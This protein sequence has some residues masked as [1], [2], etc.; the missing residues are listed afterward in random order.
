MKKVTDLVEEATNL[1]E[2]EELTK[3]QTLVGNYN[4]LQMK[5]G[6]LEVNKA[7]LLGNVFNIKN[8][9]G[10]FQDE[11]KDKYGDIIIDI[12]SGEFKDTPKQDANEPNS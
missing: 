10:K 1:I 5:V 2:K 9:L 8:E 11:L 6:E 7:D 3:L 12:Q 4:A